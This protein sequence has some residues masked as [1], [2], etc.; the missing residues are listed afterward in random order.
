LQ[1]TR[2][3][4][5]T[6]TFAEAIVLIVRDDAGNDPGVTAPITVSPGPPTAI[7]LSSDPEWLGGDKHATVTARVIDDWNNGVPNQTVDFTLLAGGGVLTPIDAATDPSGVAR[8]DYHSPREPELSTVRATSGLL[9]STL[10]IE[11]AFVDPNEVPG[12]ITNYPNPFH[13]DDAPTTIAYKIA[14]DA[15]VTVRIYSL[16]GSEVLSVEFP[17]GGTGGRQGLNE[18]RWDGRN[19]AGDI[20]AT[21]GYLAVVEAQG[22]G[23]TLHVMRRRIGLVR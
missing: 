23:E 9:Q 5:E 19:G 16:L 11:T 21:G 20:V 7:E 12:S 4:Q 3:V 10:D 13:P 15:Q 1:G 14:A 22:A 8:A 2:S 17:A 18:F 6:Y